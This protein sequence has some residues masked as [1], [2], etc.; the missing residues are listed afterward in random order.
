MLETLRLHCGRDDGHRID[1]ILVLEV[2]K[3]EREVAR[4][5]A[6]V[7]Q[8]AIALSREITI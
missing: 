7:G 2:G 3:R 4:S 5:R 6:D 1:R 8:Y